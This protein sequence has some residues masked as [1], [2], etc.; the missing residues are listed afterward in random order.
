MARAPDS[1][2][3]DA[4]RLDV[5]QGKAASARGQL[6]AAEPAE[7][8]RDRGAAPGPAGRRGPH[9]RCNRGRTPWASRNSGIRKSPGRPAASGTSILSVRRSSPGATSAGRRSRIPLGLSSSDSVSGASANAVAPRIIRGAG[10]LRRG[11]ATRCTGGGAIR[12]GRGTLALGVLAR[13]AR[14]SRCTFPITALRVTPL[15]SKPA[16][17]LALLPSIQCCLS[18]STISSVQAICRL[19]RQFSP[20]AAQYAESHSVA[21]RGARRA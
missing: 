9:G 2:L 19:V 3:P 10:E 1:P 21:W 17:W 4:G 6:S 16:I 12:R 5:V 18:C 11:P 8:D 7:S 15:P 20:K 13:P 14:P